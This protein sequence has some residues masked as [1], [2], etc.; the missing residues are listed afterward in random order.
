MSSTSA[1][2]KRYICPPE[3]VFLRLRIIVM[4]AL[5]DGLLIHELFAQGVAG[6]LYKSDDLQECL[7]LAVDTVMRDRPYLSSTANAEYLVAMQSPESIV[8]LDDE[9]RQVLK[10][11]AHGEH[12]GEIAHGMGITLRRVYWVRQKLR[13]RFGAKTN[14]HLIHRAAV[15]GFLYPYD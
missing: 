2:L 8:T 11:L 4:G 3:Y 10:R 14:E 9:L 6:Y 12:V 1:R 13:Q 5:V 15:E 7:P